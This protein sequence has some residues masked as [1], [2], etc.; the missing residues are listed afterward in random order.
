MSKN[1]MSSVNTMTARQEMQRSRG[2]YRTSVF[3][4]VRLSVNLSYFG[5]ISL[6]SI[7]EDGSISD[8]LYLST[9][10]YE[11]ALANSVN[12][13]PCVVLRLEKGTG[14]KSILLRGFIRNDSWNFNKGDILY[15][16]TITAGS[17]T[18]I[19]PSSTGDIV[20]IVGRAIAS[21]IIYFNPSYDYYT[22]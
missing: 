8:I 10:G 7:Y 6:E 18:N 12:T 3:N 4:P 15:A 13:L 21:N 9:N 5:D 20:Q 16:D 11:K 22:I 1:I 19:K 14:R 2:S 17:I